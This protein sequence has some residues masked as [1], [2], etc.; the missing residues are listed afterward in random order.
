MTI[1]VINV[2]STQFR[3]HSL[4]SCR[5]NDEYLM[6]SFNCHRTQNPEEVN[7]KPRLNWNE[8]KFCLIHAYSY[9]VYQTSWNHL[10]LLLLL[11]LLLSLFCFIIIRINSVLSPKKKID[12]NDSRGMHF[13]A[14]CVCVCCC[15]CFI[16]IFY[17]LVIKHIL[18]NSR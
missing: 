18:F 15:C 11:L 9:L 14:V 5:N 2:T 7:D 4:H 6:I 10:W 3:F 8:I 17:L 13:F 16:I 12:A 1:L